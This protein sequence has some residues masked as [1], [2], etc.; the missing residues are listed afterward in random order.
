V[1]SH[2][3]LYVIPTQGPLLLLGAAFDQVVLAPWQAMYAVAYPIT[4]VAVLCWAAR[5]LFERFVVTRSG[6]M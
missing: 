6:G 4:A 5:R 2:P 3:L 1:W